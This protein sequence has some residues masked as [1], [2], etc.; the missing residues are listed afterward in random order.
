M[1]RI[2]GQAGIEFADAQATLY[3]P[4]DFLTMH[5]DT[6]AGQNRFAA[7]VLN[8]TPIWR[9][10]WG[11]VLQFFDARMHVSG[12]F[13]PCF[14]AL[15]VFLVPSEHAVSQVALQGANRYSITGWLRSR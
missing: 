14:N 5:T 9:A 15:N 7:F 8:M 1:R 10:D 12:G 3:K 4:G 2:T 13:V 6:A 11:G